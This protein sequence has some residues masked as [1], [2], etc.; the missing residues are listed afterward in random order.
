MSDEE[1]E[2]SH[3]QDPWDPEASPYVFEEGAVN[4][5]YRLGLLAC[6][7]GEQTQSVQVIPITQLGE[8]QLVAVPSNAWH[9]KVAKRILPAGSFSRPTSVEVL[10]VSGEEREEPLPDAKIKLWVGFLSQQYYDA[11]GFFPEA[12]S[13]DYIFEA[14]VGGYLFPFGQSLFDLA[15]EHFAFFSATEGETPNPDRGNKAEGSGSAGVEMRLDKMESSVMEIFEMVKNLQG[16]NPSAP[17]Q[18]ALR[19]TQFA[20]TATVIKPNS[21]MAQ[22]SMSGS[23]NPL[24]SKP[25]QPYPGID[26]GV[27]E[28]AMQ[29]G[30]KP[31]VMEQVSRLMGKNAKAQ[32]VKDVNQEVRVDPLSEIEDEEEEQFAVEEPEFGAVALPGDPLQRAV[33]QLADIVQV[34]S[35]DKKKKR[36]TSKIDSALEYSGSTGSDGG[37][38]GTGKRSAAARRALRSMLIE[39]P[40]EIF[41]MIERLMSED[42][43]SQTLLPGVQAPAVTARAWVE[44]RSHIGAYKTVAHSAW[45]VAGALDCLKSGQINAARARL[46]VLLLQLDQSSVDKGNWTLASELSLEAAPPFHSLNLHS[47]PMDGESPY[48]KLLDGRW[49]EI[50]LAHLREQEDYQSKRKQLGRSK[51]DDAS[52]ESSPK[53]KP[54]A[55]AK[56]KPLAPETEA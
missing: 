3:L 30:L 12:L 20:P 31:E 41:S 21:S 48:S 35:E 56:G 25:Q 4:P 13:A 23:A 32:K 14:S 42:L 47:G 46:A 49:A 26:Q 18:P 40:E 27:M 29:A 45:G 36:L 24:R 16:Q 7:N 5:N 52:E 15:N 39:S 6:E 1:A 22:S 2:E 38:I 10:A 53:R 8:K 37:S 44:H 33:V 54:K 11:L 51:K 28:A 55:K 17:R 43:T 19:R 34:L 9:K 50:A